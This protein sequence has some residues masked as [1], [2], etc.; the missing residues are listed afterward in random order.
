MD[1]ASSNSLRTISAFF[2]PV[3]AARIDNLR[4]IIIS[5]SGEAIAEV[6]EELLLACNRGNGNQ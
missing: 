6:I 4:C 1:R 3:L 5:S 2:L